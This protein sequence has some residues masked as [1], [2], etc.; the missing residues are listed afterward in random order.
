MNAANK[1]KPVRFSA[2]HIL[3]REND[4]SFHFYIIQEGEV[5]IFKTSDDGSKVPLAVVTQGASIGEFAMIDRLPRSATAVAL[6]EVSAVEV[7]EA[8]Y[9]QLLEDL[10]DWAVSVM[11]ALVER[12][13]HTNE[14]IRRAHTVDKNIKREIASVE[15][16]SEKSGVRKDPLDDTENP[17]LI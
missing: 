2:G 1:I 14:I 13:R 11:K 3:F 16:D 15:Y 8:A 4:Q 7:S 6:T 9:R 10:P 17:D 5:E 12:I